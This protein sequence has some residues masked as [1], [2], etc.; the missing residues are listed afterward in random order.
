MTV[1]YTA[2]HLLDDMLACMDA[3][4]AYI[5]LLHAEAGKR[6]ED[7]W[8]QWIRELARAW[9]QGPE[10]DI[11]SDE[12]VS[13]WADR[14]GFIQ[15]HAEH[16]H[17]FWIKDGD[18]GSLVRAAL[19]RWGSQRLER[20]P[21]EPEPAEAGIKV[22]LTDRQIRFLSRYLSYFQE[23]YEDAEDFNEDFTEKGC[24]L[25]LSECLEVR[26]VFLRAIHLRP[27]LEDLET[28]ITVEEFIEKLQY[29][30]QNYEIR[31][32]DKMVLEYPA[33]KLDEEVVVI[34]PEQTTN[35]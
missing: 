18:A 2:H 34:F 10:T 31:A 22:R 4:A 30:P 23:F 11:P 19:R 7:D 13:A 35:N 20:I 21:E 12:E 8:R 15:G 32:L 17:G 14:E 25:T 27:Y 28:K 1:I 9:L 33:I 29:Y 24:E 5:R 3:D 6:L 16:P 26:S